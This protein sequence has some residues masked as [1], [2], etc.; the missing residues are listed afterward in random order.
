MKKIL[1]LTALASCPFLFLNAQD[2]QLFSCDFEKGIPSDFV[3]IDNDYGQ[4]SENA[5]Q[6]GF[7]IGVP[8]V[9][10][11][12]DNN[13][14]A[15]STSSYTPPVSRTDDWMITPG[16]KI[17]GEGEI[18]LSWMACSASSN[19]PDGYSVYISTTGGEKISDFD[20]ENPVFSIR[21]EKNEW[22]R[23]AVDLTPYKGQTIYIAFVNTTESQGTL[24]YIDDIWVGSR[25]FSYVNDF[26]NNTDH[27][28]TK[29]VVPVEATFVTSPMVEE[30]EFYTELT[31]NGE[32]FTQKHEVAVKAE[33]EYTFEL[34]E[35]LRVEKGETVYYS[36][37]LKLGDEEYVLDDAVTYPDD[38]DFV[39]RFV[40]E[41]LTGT[42]CINC[43]RGIVALQ[44]MHD[45]YGE[46]FI[47]VSV[48]GDDV[49]EIEDYPDFIYFYTNMGYPSATVNRKYSG[50]VN[51]VKNYCL[52]LEDR[53]PICSVNAYAKFTDESRD[54]IRVEVS[55]AFSFSS[56]N[57]GLRFGFV[58][59]EDSVR[60]EG[61]DY[62][63]RNGYAN[64]YAGPMGGFEN[65]PDPVPADQMIYRHVARALYEGF[66]GIDESITEVVKGEAYDKVFE[67]DLPDNIINK[68]NLG[69]VVMVIDE[70]T[71]EIR[72][73][74]FSKVYGRNHVNSLED[75]ADVMPTVD[76]VSNG[77]DVVV[78]LSADL[79][80]SKVVVC[81]MSG[82]IVRTFSAD[83]LTT[84]FAM[85]EG[86]YVIKVYGK[87]NAV[88]KKF[89][90]R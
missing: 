74:D 61:S 32:V 15:T 83:T 48:H 33:S 72:N 24:L 49:M 71:T 39:Y 73:S 10:C 84:G 31:V 80:G 78:S 44:E 75:V 89:A 3:L 55:S 26:R 35:P 69:I 62:D 27:Y 52:V 88:V 7:K 16:I 19:N 76:V 29:P 28:V 18:V 42:W 87:Q 45:K 68:D 79:L 65:L 8:W 70:K 85:P 81:D 90:V 37:K 36:L 22:M 4:P 11:V 66:V 46:R 5:A 40:A 6:F 41:E 21:R 17:E 77:S 56:E 54:K 82:R 12:L 14:V 9:V 20:R 25:N 1:L 13:V 30:S 38:N 34:D 47:P 43:P 53:S 64:G 67:C 59:V 2:V 86:I 58:L 51:E 23:H 50:D 57:T 60:G 63:Q